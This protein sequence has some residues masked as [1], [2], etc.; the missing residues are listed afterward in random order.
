MTSQEEFKAAQI[1]SWNNAASAWRKWWAVFEGGAQT[2]SDRLV[3]LAEIK[4]GHRVLDI[5]T[6]IGEPAITAADRAKPDGKVTA[7]D[8]SREMLAIA[9][10]RARERRVDN[11]THF[12]SSDAEAYAYPASSFNAAISRLGLMFLPNLVPTM[13]KIRGSLVPGGIFAAA[14][15][16]HPEKAPVLTLAQRTAAEQAGLRP[17]ASGSLGSFRLADI[18]SLE[19]SLAQAGFRN[20]RSERLTVPFTFSS[21]GEFVNFHRAINIPVAT[22]LKNLPIEK[23]EEVWMAI[24]QS[25]ERFADGKGAVRVDNEVVC[26]RGQR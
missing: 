19:N 9:R 3:E 21:I 4:P 17:P 23:Q 26:T 5:A 1:A 18:K 7:I 6:G 25:V 11:L 20:I 8:I 24:G 16:S 22:M 14:V 2:L 10:E 12:E 13:Q 15:W